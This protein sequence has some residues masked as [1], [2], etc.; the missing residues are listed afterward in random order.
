MYV[1]RIWRQ[2]D[3]VVLQLYEKNKSIYTHKFYNTKVQNL[4]YMYI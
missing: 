2:A 3:F 1:F 4:Y